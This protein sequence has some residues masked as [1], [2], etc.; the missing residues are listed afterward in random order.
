MYLEKQPKKF[1]LPIQ[2]GAA[3]S[4]VPGALGSVGLS[5]EFQHQS[6]QAFDAQSP[7]PLAAPGLL[8]RPEPP[9]SYRHWVFPKLTLLSHHPFVRALQD[10]GSILISRRSDFTVAYP[11]PGHLLRALLL[12]QSWVKGLVFLHR[13]PQSQDRGG[14][15]I[16]LPTV[17]L[18]F[19]APSSYDPSSFS[20][21]S[22]PDSP[23]PPYS[24]IT[25]V[26][27]LLFLSIVLGTWTPSVLEA[28][29]GS[30]FKW[31]VGEYPQERGPGEA[32]EGGKKRMH[33]QM[34]G[35]R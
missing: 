1:A 7:Q 22:L 35:G 19:N 26:L 21:L 17:C 30:L 15:V 5:S 27:D 2:A 34:C 20:R 10:S 29:T 14:A 16:P 32:E 9:A 25:L 3:P 4:A 12:S 13:T 18:L 8:E 23:S 11:K 33:V 28:E 6:C 31:F 24:L